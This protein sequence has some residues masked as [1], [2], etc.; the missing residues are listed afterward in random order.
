MRDQRDEVRNVTIRPIRLT[1]DVDAAPESAADAYLRLHLL[2]HRLAIPHDQLDGIFGA[3]TNVVWTNLGPVAVP[4]IDDVRLRVRQL[5]GS[6]TCTASTSSR[7][8]STTWS[9][10]AC[11]SPTPSGCASAPTSPRAPS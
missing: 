7:A 1:I 10:R 11:A 2:S 9:R 4:E 5:G 6:C 8:W 3:L